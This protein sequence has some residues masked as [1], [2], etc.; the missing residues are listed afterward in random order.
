MKEFFNV[1][2]KQRRFA[3][4][5]DGSSSD[6]SDDEDKKKKKKKEEKKKKAKQEESSDESDKED[7]KKGVTLKAGGKLMAPPGKKEF[8]VEVETKPVATVNFLEFEPEPVKKVI[9]AV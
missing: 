8:K 2:Y 9:N 3:Q 6:S 5:E 7:K 4:A 1:K